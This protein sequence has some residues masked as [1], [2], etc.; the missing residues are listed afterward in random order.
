M[1][2]NVSVVIPTYNSARFVTA[3]VRSALSQSAPP[4][5]VIVIDDGSQDS[6]RTALSPYLNAIK[7]IYQENR[8]V[9]AARNRGVQ[10]AKGRHIAFLDADDIWLPEK[11]ALQTEVMDSHPEFACVHTDTSVIDAYGR[12]VKETANPTRQ[13]V[14]GMVFDEFFKSNMAVVLL[15][16]VLMRRQ[17]F[18]TVGF[19]DERHPSVQDHFFFLRLAWRY[20][21]YFIP[22]PLVQYRITPG[23]LSRRDTV[24]NLALRKQLLNEFIAE[25]ADHFRERPDLLRRKWRSFNLDA[26]LQLFFSR[27]L[28]PSHAYLRQALGAGPKAWLYYLLTSLLERWLRR[29]VR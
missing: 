8:G 29:P 21:I 20:P 10:L 7:Y 4:L 5:E 15:S 24:A 26:G 3:A 27:D 28:Q 6:T 12:I 25:H 2:R 9:Y 17:C 22:K 13:S 14:N 11:L 1:D 19:F 23:S 16:T 18:D